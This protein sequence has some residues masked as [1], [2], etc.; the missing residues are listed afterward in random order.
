MIKKYFFSAIVLALLTGAEARSQENQLV[1]MW[2]TDSL[3]KVPESVF[4]DKGSNLLYVSNI[5]GQ[6]GEKDGK[7]SIGKVALDGKIIEV[8]WVSGL[9]A[10]KGMGLYQGNL[11]VADLTEVV[12]INTKSGKITSRIPVEGAVFLNDIT[13]DKGGIIFVSDS[14]KGRV[15]RIEN[16]KVSTYLDSLKG[17]NGLLAHGNDFY[18]LDAGTMYKVEKNKQLTKITEGMDGGTD[19]IE[20]VKGN[21]FLVSCWSGVLYYVSADGTRQKLLDTREQKINTADIGYDSQKKIVYVPTFF[22]NSV[23]AYELK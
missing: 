6:A 1:K 7:G 10:P 19:G 13:I 17:P 9:N 5:D 8:D 15:H 12:V 22:K 2:E 16:G 3:L 20:N 11:Y 4:Y 23:I 14:R 18:V 21:D